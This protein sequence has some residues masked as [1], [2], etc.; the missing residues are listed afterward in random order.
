M[1]ERHTDISLECPKIE[2][3]VVLAQLLT[4]SKMSVVISNEDSNTEHIVLLS[5]NILFKFQK[6]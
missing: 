6:I 4:L 1:G 2:A 5:G 3:R